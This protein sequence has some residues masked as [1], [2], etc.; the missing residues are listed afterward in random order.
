MRYRT[1]FAS[2]LLVLTAVGLVTGCPKKKVEPPAPTQP[3]RPTSEPAKPAETPTEVPPDKFPTQPVETAPVDQDVD[4]LNR[5]NPL[6]TVYFAYDKDDLDDQNRSVLKQ[7]ADWLKSNR[8]YHVRIE[9]HC[10]ERGTVKYNL[11][12]GE[13]RANSVRE[14]LV[15]LGIPQDRFRIVSYGTERPADPGHGD[16][17]WGKN[18]RAEFWFEP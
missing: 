6:Q 17:A 12:L 15:A 16:A 8:N 5:K 2:M 11:S 9:G 10:D 13:R 14:Y 18:R 7:N 3:S 4:Q 1:H